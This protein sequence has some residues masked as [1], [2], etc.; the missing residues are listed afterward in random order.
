MCKMASIEI[1]FLLIVYISFS[2]SL[3]LQVNEKKGNDSSNC[4]QQNGPPCQSLEYIADNIQDTTTLTVT[5]INRKLKL[6]KPVLFSNFR[7]LTLKGRSYTEIICPFESNYM[8]SFDGAGI[9]IKHSSN[10]TLINVSIKDCGTV[11]ND[12]YQNISCALL[13]QSCTNVNLTNV[14]ILN[15]YGHGLLF[16]NNS[17]NIV[18]DNCTFNNSRDSDSHIRTGGVEIVAKVEERRTEYKFT[19]SKFFG[20]TVASKHSYDKRG[21]G[22]GGGIALYLI[23]GSANN[24]INITQCTFKGNKATR[25]GGLY[26]HCESCHNN[27]IS[28]SE[29]HFISNT[30]IEGGG[31][32]VAILGSDPHHNSITFIENKI[33]S[34][35]GKYGGGAALLITYLN[36]LYHSNNVWYRSC[37]FLNN[38]G[39]ISAAVDI[40]RKINPDVT[41][42][43]GVKVNFEKCKFSNNVVNKDGSINQDKK[44]ESGIVFTFQVFLYFHGLNEFENNQGTALYMSDADVKVV[45]ARMVF[46]NNTGDT[47]G[48]IL[49][50]GDSFIVSDGRNHFVFQNNIASYGGAIC[51]IKSDFRYFAF[52]ETCFLQKEDKYYKYLDVYEFHGNKASTNIANDIFVSNLKPCQNYFKCPNKTLSTFFENYTECSGNISFE[53]NNLSYA[54]VTDNISVKPNYTVAPGI[55]F[56]LNLSQAD[57]FNKEVGELFPLSASFK[58]NTSIVIDEHD[59][60]VTRGFICFKGR[61]YDSATLL[62]QSNTAATLRASTVIYMSDCPPGF[63]F[64]SSTKICECF[65]ENSFRIHCVIFKTEAQVK[66][67]NWAG[68]LSSNETS[69]T[70][71]VGP[72]ALSFC[73]FKNEVP[74][75]QFYSLPSKASELEMLVCSDHRYG[76]LCGL[77]RKGYTT[78]YNSPNF[79][80]GTENLCSYGIFFYILSEIVPVTAFFLVIVVFDIPLTSGSLHSFIF[81]AQTLDVFYISVKEGVKYE[82]FSKA[83]V[84]VFEIFYGIFNLKFFYSDSLSFCVFKDLTAMDIFLI[85]YGTVVYAFFLIFVTVCIMKVNSLHMCIKICHKFGRRNIRKS[86][87]NGLTAVVV[88]YYFKCLDIF[89]SILVPAN[90]YV[91]SRKNK[92]VTLFNGELEYLKGNHWKY[93]IPAFICLFIIILPPPLFI[94]G[95]SI[96]QK[97]TENK[98]QQKGFFSTLTKLRQKFKPFLNSFQKCFRDECQ[99]FAGLFFLY[100]ILLVLPALFSNSSI[101]LKYA[102]AEIFLLIIL[103]L[104]FLF[105]PFKTSWHN[106]IDVILLANLVL[107]NLITLHNHYIKNVEYIHNNFQTVLEIIQISLI[108]IPAMY[109]VGFGLWNV[110]T[111]FHI[112]PTLKKKLLNTCW[113]KLCESRL[114]FKADKLEDNPFPARLLQEESNEANYWTFED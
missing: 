54:T 99:F 6:Q 68:Y 89:C 82:S 38:H 70:F 67:G 29:S 96:L 46:K 112:I 16:L 77:C 18:F 10:L 87:I 85:Q 15:P 3:S 40:N 36:Y 43:F 47:G 97:L 9:Q 51:A 90:L 11:A 37:K 58:E 60:V 50:L 64:N 32:Y 61:P 106:T 81:Y 72:C 104:H 95:N 13:V 107:V 55:P 14:I 75:S 83:L 100:R 48:A 7:K 88:L 65:D 102:Y 25:G 5:F 56:D 91:K 33:E 53:A 98:K 17:G 73:T 4:L 28:V 110:F 1:V 111:K 105:R 39:N 76:T 26:I 92:T 8:R 30:A 34:N 45:D 86:I 23:A 84:V 101:S 78:Y 35:N 24:I 63:H 59:L 20:N 69:D 79:K 113:K 41:F 42:Y 49:L 108:S 27:T 21:S 66:A 57:Q 22:N 93:A 12:Y 114:R 80:C 2:Y 52:T 31:M 19:N 62:L 103:L 94:L 71:A 44:S 74:H 109:I